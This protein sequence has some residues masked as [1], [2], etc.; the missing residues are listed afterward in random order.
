LDS[1]TI[2]LMLTA[3][4]LHASWHSLVKSGENIIVILA[5][6]GAVA[7]VCATATVPFV[8]FPSPEVWPVLLLSIGLHIVYKICLASAYARGEF[9]QAF[10]LSRGMVP[11]FAT[12][13]A[14]MSQGQVPS[15]NQSAGIVL[16][17]CGLSLLA[18]DKLQGVARWPL[19]LAAASAGAA[20]ASYSV[21]DAYGTR[22]FGNWSGFTA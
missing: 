9:G 4:L 8:A 11:L 14:F 18:L 2:S 21:I 22:L 7:G 12:F 20:V 1:L 10:P 13:I 5:G 15:L 17:G 19:L 6:M 3:R 16:V